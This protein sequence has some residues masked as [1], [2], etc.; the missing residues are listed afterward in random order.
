VVKQE[1][2]AGQH[3]GSYPSP[4]TVVFV[5]QPDGSRKAKPPEKSQSV[6]YARPSTPS[7]AVND[8][9]SISEESGL[10]LFA[11]RIFNFAVVHV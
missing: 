2:P 10:R 11:M 5:G 3:R 4:H 1:R 8:T 9:S 7:A 6:A